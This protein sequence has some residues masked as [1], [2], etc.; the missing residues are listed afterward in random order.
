MKLLPK[1][2][3]R[4]KIDTL[5]ARYLLAVN[6]VGHL[7]TKVIARIR[8][9]R[10]KLAPLA[11][12]HAPDVL[13]ENAFNA[14]TTASRVSAYRL[15]PAEDSL[16]AEDL[17]QRLDFEV[18]SAGAS[19]IRTQG[20]AVPDNE[21]KVLQ[22]ELVKRLPA[23]RQELRINQKEAIRRITNHIQSALAIAAQAAYRH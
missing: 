1:H 7:P 12:S 13:V 19:L 21:L 22:T 11:G 15:C 8:N 5:N 9:P 16:S 6:P 4:Y 17:V 14:I 2:I 23:L 3:S 20:E 10:A 18:T